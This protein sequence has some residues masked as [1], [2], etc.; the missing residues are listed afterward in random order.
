MF[1]ACNSMVRFFVGRFFLLGGAKN[2]LPTKKSMEGRPQDVGRRMA[3]LYPPST[4][5]ALPVM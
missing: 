1:L 3:C 4:T 2:D 5:R